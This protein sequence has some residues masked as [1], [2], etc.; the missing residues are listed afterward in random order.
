MISE[1]VVGIIREYLDHCSA[2]R[3]EPTLV[4]IHWHVDG[5]NKTL[6]LG[7]EVNAAL[8]FHPTLR[9]MERDGRVV[10][11]TSGVREGVTDADMQTA[12][13][14]YRKEFAAEYKNLQGH[15]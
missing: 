10:F 4:G 2:S 15:R 12:D 7:A 14:Q 9:T 11:S 13:A 6:P 3:V 1:R 5:R 8:A